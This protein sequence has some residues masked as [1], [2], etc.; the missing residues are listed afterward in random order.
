M[1][2]LKIMLLRERELCEKLKVKREFIY[3]CRNKGMPCVKL[4]NRTIRYRLQDVL[5]WFEENNRKEC[6]L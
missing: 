2:G 4:G 3:K 1:K 6:Q 5:V